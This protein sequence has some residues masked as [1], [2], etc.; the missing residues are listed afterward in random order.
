MVRD[1]AAS[2]RREAPRENR[3]SFFFRGRVT[4]FPKEKEKKDCLIASHVLHR[5]CDNFISPFN[6]HIAGMAYYP[7]VGF[8]SCM[9]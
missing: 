4:L 3:R 9:W 5:P 1:E 8:I 7:V 6:F 2:T